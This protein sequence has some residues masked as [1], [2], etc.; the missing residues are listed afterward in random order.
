MGA[1]LPRRK[2]QPQVALD[3]TF[4]QRVFLFVGVLAVVFS[5]FTR[6]P[7]AFAVGG[8][9]PWML[10]TI[11]K[12][13]NMPVAVVFFLLWQWAQTYSRELQTLIDQEALGGG[14]FG[15]S[16]ERAYW[17]TLAS[18]VTLALC[19]RAT[20]GNLPDPTP[21]SRTQ[22][23]RWQPRDMIILYFAAIPVVTFARIAGGLSGALDQP[24]SAV[25]NIKVV[26][27][28][29]LFTNV[30]STGKGRNFLIFVVVFE[31]ISG[32]TGLF[33]DFKSIFIML[34]LAAIAVRIPW[35]FTL[36][37]ASVAWLTI[38]LSLA[39]FWSGVKMDYRQFATG[40]DESQSI[41]VSLG[42]R[43]G[44]IGDRAI[45]PSS[46]D[47]NAASYALLTRFAYIDIFGSV[48][49]VQEASPEPETMRQWREGLAHVLQPRFLFPDKAPLS[50]SDV[51]VRLAKG[52][53]TEAVR[54]GTSISVGYVAEN[55]ADLGFP[56]MLAGIAV[57]GFL[58]GSACRYFMMKR[59]LP[60]MVREATVIVLVYSVAQGGLEISL[61]KLLGAIVMTTLVY[62]LIVRFAYPYV[63]TWLNRPPGGRK[64]GPRRFRAP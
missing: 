59:N 23:M 2:A 58:I 29:I 30:L 10:I 31:T 24:M 50:D 17:Y 12:R 25:R 28:I 6:D 42:D 43:L 40:S 21:Q 56:G 47:W 27:L 15:V 36:S 35:S 38:I 19:M 55:F 61:P 37:I 7:I 53:P 33:A 22:H 5:P 32:F 16:V 49:T 34:G 11:I 1:A 45:T 54:E 46:V 41:S 51:Y 3:Y 9:V 13:P 18:V 44:Y 20:L 63:L 26:V 52:D 14:L 64:L 8:I 62:M 48:I 39:I 57:I 4:L 60:W